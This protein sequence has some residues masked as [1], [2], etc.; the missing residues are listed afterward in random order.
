MS[1]KAKFF[2]YFYSYELKHNPEITVF[3]NTKNGMC[4][5]ATR[6]GNYGP[7]PFPYRTF[8]IGKIKPFTSGP[9]GGVLRIMNYA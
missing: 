4:F 2:I 9:W 3:C 8:T 5:I 7:E 6:T 1:S